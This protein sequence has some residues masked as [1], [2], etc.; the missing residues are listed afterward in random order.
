MC[1]VRQLDLAPPVESMRCVLS[2]TTMRPPHTKRG[3][4][5]YH[6]ILCLEHLS[7]Q[8][9]LASWHTP[10]RGCSVSPKE[11]HNKHQAALPVTPNFHARK[12]L[13]LCGSFLGSILA[14]VTGTE[15]P[16]C[17]YAWP[18]GVV[19]CEGGARENWQKPEIFVQQSFLWLKAWGLKNGPHYS[20]GN[21]TVAKNQKSLG[22]CSCSFCK[23]MKKQR[24]P[25]S[26]TPPCLWHYAKKMFSRAT[27]KYQPPNHSF[28]KKQP[29]LIQFFTWQ[30]W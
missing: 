16:R 27:N 13:L 15:E 17:I 4:P 30:T 24:Q 10:R 25:S 20:P 11:S 28:H 23:F 14:E 29:E 26:V 19:L 1:M 6:V 22:S 7:F 2:V 3:N 8:P 12:A 9:T 5:L 18:L 21:P